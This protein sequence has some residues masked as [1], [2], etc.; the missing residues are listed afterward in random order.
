MYFSSLAAHTPSSD[1][2]SSFQSQT[3]PSPPP[4]A[5]VSGSGMFPIGGSARKRV[6]RA[7][8][9]CRR[10]KVKCNGQKPCAH[11]VAFGEECAYVDVKDRSA[12]SRRYVE[13]L[14]ARVVQ[15][16]TGWERCESRITELER[17]MAVLLGGTSREW[18]REAKENLRRAS[19]PVGL[20]TF[21]QTRRSAEMPVPL[22]GFRSMDVE[23]STDLD[24]ELWFDLSS[25]SASHLIAEAGAVLQATS[26]YALPV[27]FA[28]KILQLK[29]VQRAPV[30]TAVQP[31]VELDLKLDTEVDCKPEL[32]PFPSAANF[33]ILLSSFVSRVHPF[34]PIVLPSKVREAWRAKSETEMRSSTAAALVF[35]VM[36][37]GAQ[38]LV[39]TSPMIQHAQ[40]SPLELYQQARLRAQHLGDGLDAG[41]V[42][43]L[44]SVQVHALLAYFCAGH[45]DASS[46][47][48][49]NARARSL[50]ISGSMDTIE[51]LESHPQVHQAITLLDSLILSLLH[52]LASE[53]PDFLS[54]S[55]PESSGFDLFHCLNMLSQLCSTSHSVGRTMLS[56][57]QDRPTS[58]AV[59]T[60]RVRTR[61]QDALLQEW[62]NKLP[63]A[64]GDTPSVNTDPIYAMGSCIAFVLLQFERLR[65]HI[66]LQKFIGQCGEEAS[67]QDHSRCM[68]IA[69]HTIQAF[70]TVSQNLPPS[71][72]LALYGE[73]LGMSAAFLGL[74]A[75][76]QIKHN[77]VGLMT[78]VES[79][80][81]GLKQLERSV[82]GTEDIRVKLSQLIINA[83]ARISDVT[84]SSESAKGNREPMQSRSSFSQAEASVNGK[85]KVAILPQSLSCVVDPSPNAQPKITTQSM[86]SAPPLM[87]FTAPNQIL[88]NSS[89]GSATGYDDF[90]NQSS[91]SSLFFDH[92]PPPSAI[93]SSVSNQQSSSIVPALEPHQHAMMADLLTLISQN[94]SQNRACTSGPYKSSQHVSESTSELPLH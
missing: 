63:F 10:K 75:V 59:D 56:L 84:G 5:S 72:W 47:F 33:N 28:S 22:S 58:N 61:Q 46:A 40:D 93:L 18:R 1:S 55:P 23:L 11:C 62:Y 70:P 77:A 8:E 35:A 48:E 7:C 14:E 57:L 36:A 43:V 2:T 29:K 42:Q 12:Y 73:C 71:P 74:T 66:A 85:S 6:V 26:Q 87:S 37:C 88:T 17:E 20:R 83:R 67:N 25:L 13:G 49:H 16:E 34:W 27:S 65:L 45:G 78:E 91:A 54:A 81:A 94:E 38:A 90:W 86:P 82:S 76:R 31:L 79:A 69:K 52:Q 53:S 3:F 39:S 80:I 92:S 41:G 21:E 15:L 30:L 32:K 44:E 19:D 9:V 24:S 60:M 51:H 68:Q 64:F 89:N 50:L 4:H